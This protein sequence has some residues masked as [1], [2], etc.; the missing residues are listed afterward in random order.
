MTLFQFHGPV[1]VVEELFPASVSVVAEMDVDERVVAGLD[2]FFDEFHAG[3]FWGMAAFF[4][5]TGRAGTNDV[6]PGRFAA[7]AARDDVVE[8]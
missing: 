8:R 2:G 3:M 4:D 7:L 5:V 6:F 1:S